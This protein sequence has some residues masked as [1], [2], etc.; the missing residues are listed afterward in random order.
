MTSTPEIVKP[1]NAEVPPG[2]LKALT[3]KLGW[4]GF[5]QIGYLPDFDDEQMPIFNIRVLI[6]IDCKY[7]IFDVEEFSNF[8]IQ[9]RRQ[10]EFSNIP[11]GEDYFEYGQAESMM[12]FFLNRLE[13]HTC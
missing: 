2:L 5:I 6:V 4:S 9:L 1:N 12:N 8:F 11:G 7:A 10:P 13:S 3:I